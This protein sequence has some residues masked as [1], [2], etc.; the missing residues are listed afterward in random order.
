VK[1]RRHDSRVLIRRA[2]DFLWDGGEASGWGH[3][4]GVH[5]MYVQTAQRLEPGTALRVTVHFRRAPP[6]SVDARV[7]RTDETGFAVEFEH[8]DGLADEIIRKVVGRAG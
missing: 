5:G 4:L 1:E 8:L 6:I 2:V 7:T 3:D